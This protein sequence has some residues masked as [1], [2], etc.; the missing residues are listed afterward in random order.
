M[1]ISNKEQVDVLLAIKNI[2][3]ISEEFHV[4][5]NFQMSDGRWAH[6]GDTININADAPIWTSEQLQIIKNE[7][8]K[9][10]MPET[11]P[12]KRDDPFND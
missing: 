11:I 2:S 12:T 3:G 4:T 10:D 8:A 6:E 1:N 7:I 5:A 9:L